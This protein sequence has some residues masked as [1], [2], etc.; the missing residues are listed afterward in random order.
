MMKIER[1]TNPE[2][3]LVDGAATPI[4]KTIVVKATTVQGQATA[5]PDKH[6]EMKATF[7][8]S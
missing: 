4:V 8:K 1:I 7:L 3:S 5:S 6:T 2:A